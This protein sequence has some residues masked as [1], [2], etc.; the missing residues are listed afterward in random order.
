[1]TDHNELHGDGAELLSVVDDEVHEGKQQW[2]GHSGDARERM[3]SKEATNDSA[4]ARFL[5]V[6]N[7]E[8]LRLATTFASFL[9]ATHAD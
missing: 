5:I 3:I 8:R 6:V 9:N 7:S 1:M 4:D 2:L